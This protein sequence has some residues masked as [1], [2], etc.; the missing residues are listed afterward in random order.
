MGRLTI[1]ALLIVAPFLQAQLHPMPG[2]KNEAPVLCT[3]CK[4]RNLR[5]QRNDGLKTYPYSGP[6][7]RHAGRY[8]D[9]TSTT[10]FQAPLGFRT[11]RAR[12][13][14]TV[15]TQRGSAPPRVYIVIGSAIS[16][17]ALDKFFTQ[18][19]PAGMKP[20][21]AIKTGRAIR[22][23]GRKP[24]EDI[25]VWHGML[26]PDATNSQWYV[27]GLDKQDNIGTAAPIDYDDRGYLYAAYSF[28][29]W[30]IVK[31]DGRTDGG[32]FPTMVQLITG[33]NPASGPARPLVKADPSGVG[34]DSIVAM[35]VGP[36]YYAV[37]ATQNDREAVWD[38][39][40]PSSPK[41]LLT[42]NAQ[43]FGIRRFDRNDAR[44]H[45]AIVTGKTRR[46]RVYDYG[47]FVRSRNPV[48]VYEN[49]GVFA[50][51]SYDES[52]NLWAAEGK[53]RVWKLTPTTLGYTA[54]AYT[55]HEGKFDQLAMHVAA[56]HI[57][58]QGKDYTG[59]LA[60]DARLLKI[61]SGALRNLNLD[62]FFRRY[63]HN[64]PA[65]YAMPA[66]YYN[67]EVMGD[68]QII[69]SGG[70]TYLMYSTIGLGDVFEIESGG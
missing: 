19:L 29:G 50:D 55:P 34:P 4:D 45:V 38:V 59:G 67:P 51:V 23:V 2:S 17:Y 24:P 20:V 13:I 44:Q 36:K 10:S 12:Y 22:G 28:T 48:P 42:R 56:G 11:A 21:T 7:K 66:G 64:S 39:T 1:A 37:T 52:G 5:G 31:D 26:Y 65:G 9:S 54:T 33:G 35:K 46:L 47:E 57:F 15:P 61:E 16:G 58:V 40:D 25:L 70:K 8:V 53:N 3:G 68:V 27:P 30:G 41:L 69:R 49:S 14:R 32:S 63:Y 6:I 43:T 62:G 18:M 60:F